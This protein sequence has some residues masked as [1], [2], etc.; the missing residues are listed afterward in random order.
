MMTPVVI[1]D[2]SSP[3]I[4]PYIHFCNEER[5]IP[6]D[7][8]DCKVRRTKGL[9]ILPMWMFRDCEDGYLSIV[10]SGKEAFF[11]ILWDNLLPM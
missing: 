5:E 4:P 11:Y 8:F 6:G 9:R 3:V 2:S 10:F 7:P 1:D